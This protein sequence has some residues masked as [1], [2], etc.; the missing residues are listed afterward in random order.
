[1]IDESYYPQVEKPDGDSARL[2]RFPR[3]R[4]S[5]LIAAHKFQGW[6]AE[7]LCLQ[8]PDLTRDEIDSALTY[9]WHHRE[10]IDKEIADELAICE[11]LQKAG[12]SPFMQE[13]RRR[14]L[15]R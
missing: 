9:Y 3:F 14:G 2:K 13:L 7:D 1:M 8:Y 6:S 11:E 15:P 5:L 10:E 12:P 4:V